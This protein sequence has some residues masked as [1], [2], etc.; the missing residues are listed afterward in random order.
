MIAKQRMVQTIRNV[1]ESFGFDPLETSSVQFL[2]ALFGPDESTDMEYFLVRHNRRFEYA[3]ETAIPNQKRSGLRYDLTVALARHVAENIATLPKPFLRHELGRVFRGENPSEGRFCQFDQL[4]ADFV[5]A[6]DLWA[7]AQII[8]MMYEVM[9]SL[10]VKEFVININDRKFC[11]G[12]PLYAD[13]PE[14]NLFAVL[15]AIDK[16]DKVGTTGVETLLTTDENLGLSPEGV[17]KIMQLFTLGESNTERLE[18]VARLMPENVTAMEGISELVE[19]L[20]Y[21]KEL[22]VPDNYVQI[23]FQV[24]RGLNYYTGPVFETVLTQYPELGSVFAGGRYDGLVSRFADI[25]A[26]AVGAAVG[27]DR[28]L[29][30]L[31]KMGLLGQ[32]KS[33]VD[34]LVAVWD[35]TQAT[36]SLEI[37]HRLRQLGMKVMVYTGADLKLKAQTT[38]AVTEEIPWFIIVGPDELANGFISIKDTRTRKQVTIPDGELEKFFGVIAKLI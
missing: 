36:K 18:L 11:N 33:V 30:A 24:V 20:R 21:V 15:R 26:P 13:F 12:L 4:D 28:L 31:Q 25:R 29:G 16:F 32:K 9:I 27:V 35:R 37:A 34:V 2:D 19:L 3:K 5:F 1:F 17:Q 6:P 14:E 7:D 10:G 23:A 38:R 8:A 22:G